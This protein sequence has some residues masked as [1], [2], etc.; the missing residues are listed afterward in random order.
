ML[1]ELRNYMHATIF[2][3]QFAILMQINLNYYNI[4]IINSFVD[5]V[6]IKS[7]IIIDLKDL[8]Y[9]ISKIKFHLEAWAFMSL[10]PLVNL[11]ES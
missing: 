1:R 8:Q 5:K 2:E 7:G 3:L 4:L 9:N 6:A 10:E 11:K